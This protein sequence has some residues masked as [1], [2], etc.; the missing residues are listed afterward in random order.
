MLRLLPVA[1]TDLDNPMSLIP[2]LDAS[3]NIELSDSF[4]TLLTGT[5]ASRMG[6]A[7]DPASLA[8]LPPEL[9]AS[10]EAQQAQ[11]ALQAKQMVDAQ[12]EGAIAQGYL[13]R[14]VGKVS[15]QLTLK[16]GQLLVNGRAVGPN[17]AQMK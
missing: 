15:A 1:A 3:L 13:I 17:L 2:K 5:A 16:G 7:P 11:Q 4:L 6:G 10:A 14:G 9:R 12:L 8:Q